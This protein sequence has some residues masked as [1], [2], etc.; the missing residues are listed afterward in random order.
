LQNSVIFSPFI[1]VLISQLRC[2]RFFLKI[3]E[4]KKTKRLARAHK[5]AKLQIAHIIPHFGFV[6]VVKIMKEHDFGVEEQVACAPIIT[7]NAVRL[8]LVVVIFIPRSTYAYVWIMLV[9][10]SDLDCFQLIQRKSTRLGNHEEGLLFCTQ[11]HF[12][13]SSTVLPTLFQMDHS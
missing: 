3:V 8:P 12:Q 2:W 13:F 7:L 6:H 4:S 5:K 1:Q 9:F 11:K 10:A